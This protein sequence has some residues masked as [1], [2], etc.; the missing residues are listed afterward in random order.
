VHY[1]VNAG[2]VPK[3]HWTQDPVEGGGRI[4]GEGCH[5]IDF[6][7]FMTGALP[8]RVSATAVR[9]GNER[10][11]DAD[12]VAITLGMADGSLGSILYVALGDK[13][14]PKERCE[15]FADGSVGVLDDFRSGVLVRDGRE[16]TLRGGAQDKGHDAEV[17]AFLEAVRT[18]APSPISLDSLVAT[19]LASFAVLDAL[20]AGEAVDLTEQLRS[21]GIEP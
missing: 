18:G 13:R 9:S 20:R 11:T 12:S 7:Q 3:T 1:R 16:E 21:F 10:E 2:F 4:V 14:F 15:I 19:T 8:V 17:A 6:V 5:F